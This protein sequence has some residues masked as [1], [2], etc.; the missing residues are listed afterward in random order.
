MAFCIDKSLDASGVLNITN[1]DQMFGF[2]ANERTGAILPINK[3]AIELWEIGLSDEIKFFKNKKTE[4]Q[5][6]LEALN[7]PSN[8]VPEYVLELSKEE[9]KLAESRKREW[10][11][12]NEIL[13]DE[14]FQLLFA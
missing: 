4:I 12:N 6:N 11:S 2:K 5:L 9:L 14:L 1:Y 13:I 7:L 10:S 3:E 8:R